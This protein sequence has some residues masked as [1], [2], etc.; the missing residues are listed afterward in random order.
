MIPCIKSGQV[1][2]TN[3]KRENRWCKD[4]MVRRRYWDELDKE[5]SQVCLVIRLC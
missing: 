4:S 5:V 3:Y 1:D 2:N